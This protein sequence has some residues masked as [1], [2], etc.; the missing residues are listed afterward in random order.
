MENFMMAS[1]IKIQ[2]MEVAYGKAFREI[3]I[4][5]NGPMDWFTDLECIYG[6]MVIAMK[7]NSRIA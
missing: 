7:G 2:S 5:E 1:G 6:L 3:N 4:L